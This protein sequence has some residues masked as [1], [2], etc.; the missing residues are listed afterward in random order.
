M[1]EQGRTTIGVLHPGSMGAAVGG[2][3]VAAGQHV[4][5]TSEDRSPATCERAERF[6]LDDVHWLNGVVNQADIILSICPPHAAREV[7]EDVRN[8]GYQ[9]IYVDANAVSPDTAREVGRVVEGVGAFFVDGGIIGGPPV[10]PGIARLFLSGP[11]APRVAR[12]FEGGPLE[13]VVLDAPVGAASALK[14]AYAAWT[15]GTSALLAD[16]LALAVREDV[17]EPLQA[18]WDEALL[19]RAD[20][21]GS[22]AA[23][24]WRWVGE[25]EEIASTFEAAGLPGGFHHAAAEVY[26]RL[27]QFKDDPDAP[28][29]A[30]LARH[31][32]TD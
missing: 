4:L 28:G 8:L 3:A 1:D 31:L 12:A 24:A 5:W 17:L 30:E 19:R 23:K 6:G 10:K 11:E 26:R 18:Q 25:M 14:M 27:E 16:V 21:L 7:A 32:L 29:G 20:G 22:A 15:K 13:V 9:G 2:A